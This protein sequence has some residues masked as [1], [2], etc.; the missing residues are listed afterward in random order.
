MSDTVTCEWTASWS[1]IPRLIRKYKYIKNNE[2]DT[3]E[4]ESSIQKIVKDIDEKVE[5]KEK[6]LF[7]NIA[8]NVRLT[9]NRMTF[10]ALIAQL[11][12]SEVL[13]Y[14]VSSNLCLNII[15]SSKGKI[16]TSAP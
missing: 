9:S 12:I 13:G 14:L 11:N 15:Q 5:A 4:I 3:E 16:N 10:Q 1:E 6:A 2:F 8:E 7:A